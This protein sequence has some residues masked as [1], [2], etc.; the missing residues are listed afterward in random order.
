MTDDVSKEINIPYGLN[1][2]LTDSQFTI[3]NAN[4]NKK[5]II[6]KKTIIP[7]TFNAD[8]D[9]FLSYE[10][11]LTGIDTRLSSLEEN[12]GSEDYLPIVPYKEQIDDYLHVFP[13]FL[14]TSSSTSTP[15]STNYSLFNLY[16][17]KNSGINYPGV[18]I[19]A[20]NSL[21]ETLFDKNRKTNDIQVGTF[22]VAATGTVKVGGR[23][24]ELFLNNEIKLIFGNISNTV[25]ITSDTS[26][27]IIARS[28]FNL[29][30]N[31][32][33]Y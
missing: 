4:E 18:N 10:T 26:N 24:L 16:N 9:I 30:W 27:F 23:N 15:S 3:Y 6:P 20:Y 8:W 33:T 1:I 29:S 17:V 28:G 2:G 19:T 25:T 14:C 21:S 32:F 22:S 7:S 11:D 12:S 5:I 31:K 13:K